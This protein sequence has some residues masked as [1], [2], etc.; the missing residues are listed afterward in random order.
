MTWADN[1]GSSTSGEYRVYRETRDCSAWF[2]GKNT[3]CV[4]AR[5]VTLANA[6]QI[7]EQHKTRDAQ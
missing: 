7:C 3:Q 4:L 6:K 1:L 5:E 2:Y